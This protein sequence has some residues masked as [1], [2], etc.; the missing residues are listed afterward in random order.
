MDRVD[1]LGVSWRFHPLEFLPKKSA[2]EKNP[3]TREDTLE[4]LAY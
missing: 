3:V 1:T 4:E 2:P